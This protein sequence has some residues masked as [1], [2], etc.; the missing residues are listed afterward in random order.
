MITSA[1][2]IALLLFYRETYSPT[3]LRRKA[4]L[5]RK[6]TGDPRYWS[7]YDER[8]PFWELI[9][10][11]FSRP[12][13]MATTEPICIFWNVYIGIVYGIL[14]LCFIAYPLVF[15]GLRGWSTSF[16]G[17]SFLGVGVGAVLAMAL[18][19]LLRR[20]IALYKH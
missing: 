13:V 1:L 2:A 17:L 5:R 20:A 16:T 18:V 15:Q 8:R 10:V 4:A 9:R 12:L 7:R 19:P 3:L 11:N 6:A 14:Y